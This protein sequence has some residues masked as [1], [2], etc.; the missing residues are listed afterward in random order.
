MLAQDV[1]MDSGKVADIV[2]DGAGEAAEV[3]RAYHEA[4]DACMLEIWKPAIVW[5]IFS[6]SSTN[7]TA[8]HSKTRSMPC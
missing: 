1:P 7:S 5:V 8:G 3:L 4:T 6:I 2:A